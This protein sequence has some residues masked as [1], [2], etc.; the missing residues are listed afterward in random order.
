MAYPSCVLP[1]VRFAGPRIGESHPSRIAEDDVETNE[2]SKTEQHRLGRLV[3][4]RCIRKARYIK[5]VH[6]TEVIK[7]E[8]YM[9]QGLE[10]EYLGWW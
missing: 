6:V 3:T 10:W 5:G 4:D 8:T 1:P 2:C 9:R 7:V